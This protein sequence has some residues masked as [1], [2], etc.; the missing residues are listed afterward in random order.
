MLPGSASPS[1]ELHVSE[2]PHGWGPR[3]IHHEKGHKRHH[4]AEEGATPVRLVTCTSSSVEGS[5]GQGHLCSPQGHTPCAV[6]EGET[7]SA[8][9]Y[10][11]Y[12][13]ISSVHPAWDRPVLALRVPHPGKSRWPP[14][15]WVVGCPTRE[16][17]L[18]V[19]SHTP[20]VTSVK[21]KDP[22]TTEF[23]L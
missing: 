19:G 12:R 13:G 10:W 21:L 14:A 23:L 3:S 17:D 8:G 1:S 2:D 16:G 22:Q 7:C 18:C 4:G 11:P 20:N 15:K 6:M 5:V 9:T